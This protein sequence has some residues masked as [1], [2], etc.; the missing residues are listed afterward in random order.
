MF[1][2][3]LLEKHFKSKKE[4]LEF[5]KK[6]KNIKVYQLIEETP[7]E[8]EVGINNCL[9]PTLIKSG[10]QNYTIKYYEKEVKNK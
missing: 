2:N 1:K 7:E 8:Y 6:N 9:K 5:Y 4:L 3:K 10:K